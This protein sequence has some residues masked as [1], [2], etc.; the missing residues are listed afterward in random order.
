MG[1]PGYSTYSAYWRG[2]KK[3]VR[4]LHSKTIFKIAPLLNTFYYM[5]LPTIEGIDY[6]PR[7]QPQLVILLLFLSPFLQDLQLYRVC[8]KCFDNFQDW[9]F[10]H[11]QSNKKNQSL[12]ETLPSTM[13]SLPM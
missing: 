1:T 6:T 4:A 7:S 5:T 3:Q 12:I 13:D 10:F 2:R 9:I 11:I 8:L